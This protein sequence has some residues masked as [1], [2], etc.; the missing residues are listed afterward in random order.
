MILATLLLAFGQLAGDEPCPVNTGDWL[1][2]S[3]SCGDAGE[4][5][6]TADDA[7]VQAALTQF[8]AD[9]KSAQTSTC[10]WHS[11]KLRE[12]REAK[13]LAEGMCTTCINFAD[14]LPEPERSYRIAVCNETKDREIAIAT[15]RF[16]AEIAYM[17]EYVAILKIQA[18]QR[19]ILAMLQCCE[20]ECSTGEEGPE[21]PD[22][23]SAGDPQD[24]P[25]NPFCSPHMRDMPDCT[26][27]QYL[28]APQGCRQVLD[29]AKADL[30]R[31]GWTLREAGIMQQFCELGTGRIDNY[32]QV[33]IQAELDLINCVSSA[34]LVLGD[35]ELCIAIITCIQTYKTT[36]A[37]A[38]QMVVAELQMLAV[39][40]AN[41]QK[42]NDLRFCMEMMSACK[43]ECD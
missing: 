18:E 23:G 9:K 11:L 43:L 27:V 28:P 34:E 33:C 25:L 37:Y 30:A 41:A 5:E 8:Q 39:D 32:I 35:D 36:I 29:E 42:A 31:D 40:M 17:Y 24:P 21:C 38:H 14:D 22:L 12:F 6:W 13:E 19:Y 15:Q 1:P 10:Y 26:C 7:C 2:P 4:C 16:N 3:F 20:L